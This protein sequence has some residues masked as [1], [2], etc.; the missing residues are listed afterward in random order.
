MSKPTSESVAL[1][2]ATV[3]GLAGQSFDVD[4]LQD[5]KTRASNLLRRGPYGAYVQAGN[6]H[7]WGND[8][9]AVTVFMEAHGGPGDCM[10]PMDYYDGGYGTASQ[11]SALLPGDW[12]IE[13]INAAVAIV[14][15]FG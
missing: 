9:T 8:R 13:F 12:Y 2:F 4:D 7:G 11:V 1:A 14:V 3:N 6:A 5:V 10:L 15:P